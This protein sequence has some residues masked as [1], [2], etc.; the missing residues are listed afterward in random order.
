MTCSGCQMKGRWG[1]RATTRRDRTV[2]RLRKL[3]CASCGRLLP[4]PDS[5]DR[6]LSTL[7][8]LSRF[9]LAPE[10]RPVLLRGGA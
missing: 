8:G 2:E 1:L 6:L 9:G 7:A 3:F 10:G 5:T 4:P